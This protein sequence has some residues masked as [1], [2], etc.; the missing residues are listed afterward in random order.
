[1]IKTIVVG[2]SAG[3]LDALLTIL[4]MLPAGFRIPVVLV[5]HLPPDRPSYLVPVLEGH[6]KLNV[7]EVEDKEPLSPRTLH[8]APPNYH[9]L[10]ERDGSLSLSVDDLVHFSRPSID[11]LFESAAI[12]YG[13]EAIGVLLTGANEDGASGLCAM[14]RAGAQTLVQSP[15]CALVKTMPEGAIRLNPNHLVLSVKEI[16]SFLAESATLFPS[17]TSA[18]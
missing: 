17:R 8:V 6:C 10:L 11:V 13:P 1:M 14:R 4:P 5:V 3:A 2:G 15:E 7:K 9:I 16:G 18:P 12:A